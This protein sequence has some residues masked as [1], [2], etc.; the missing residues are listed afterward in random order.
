[1]NLPQE[2]QRGILNDDVEEVQR[3]C[4]DD[5]VMR[6]EC[7]RA[8][9]LLGSLTCT[10]RL[11][12]S[13]AHVLHRDRST[14]TVLHHAANA[15]HAEILAALLPLLGQDCSVDVPSCDVRLSRLQHLC[16]GVTPLHLA[17]ASRQVACVQ[18]L[19]NAR[20]NARAC[21]FNGWAAADHA[22]NCQQ[23]LQLLGTAPGTT[24]ASSA[25]YDQATRERN[26]RRVAELQP[27]GFAQLLAQADSNDE[28][29]L[30]TLL[31]AADVKNLRV[32]QSTALQAA[33]CLG[34]ATGVRTIL[35][36][37]A[38]QSKFKPKHGEVVDPKT[39]NLPPG[40]NAV[41]SMGFM[42]LHC[43]VETGYPDCIGLLLEATADV[44]AVTVDAKYQLGQAA[45]VYCPGGRTALHL[46]VKKMDEEAISSLLEGGAKLDVADSFGLTPLH[47]CGEAL[48]LLPPGP[49][50]IK[51]E[52]IAAQLGASIDDRSREELEKAQRSRQRQLQERIGAAE[53]QRWAEVRAADASAI[54]ERYTPLNP[55]VASGEAVEQQD[56][57]GVVR[58]LHAPEAP[59]AG[60]FERC[61]LVTGSRATGVE[62]PHPGVFV[63]QLLSTEICEAIWLET[64]NYAKFAPEQGLPQP[65]RHD[66]CLDLSIVFPR[67]LSGIADAAQPVIRALLPEHLHSV[68]LR[69]AFRTKNFVGRD[70]A[71]KRHVDKYA[72]TLNVCL[73]KTADVR[74]S[75]VFFFDDVSVDIP[76]YRHEHE[77]GLA[78]LH[79][80][81]EWHQ[82]E[83]LSA[84]VRSSIIMWFVVQ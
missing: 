55:A 70:E 50:R 1:M 11:A 15:G 76:A 69:H 84:G 7:L 62:E 21:D 32:S 5:A 72:V 44:D 38:C 4:G 29:P 3:L 25:A 83:P 73:H 18:L 37:L 23:V 81:K 79:S 16:G 27:A 19:L 57:Q 12:V 17:A 36:F 2:L 45:T 78:V 51:L 64:E 46:A 43:A 47:E 26:E 58:W 59:S 28:E 31:Q 75:G 52:R 65:V 63:F 66:G 6:T 20:A 10:T 77:V 33:I 68:T 40:I 82:T 8:A 60:G 35:E 54:K 56:G 41:D 49:K 22:R 42:P 30:R 9:V 74:G 24:L 34:S 67:L 48:A 61:L 53:R 80:S 71:F 13:S 39:A 14:W